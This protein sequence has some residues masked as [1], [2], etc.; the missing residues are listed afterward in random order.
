MNKKYKILEHTADI[1]VQAFGKNVP[2]LF[3]N[4]LKGM[5]HITKPDFKDQKVKV[6]FEIKADDF[7][8]LLIEFLSEALYFS[9]VRDEVYE[10]VEFK[11]FNT[12][13]YIIKGAFKG[14][15]IKGLG[16]EIK[17]VTWH[18]ALVEKKKDFW[19]SKILF[20]I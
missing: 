5:A 4:N 20:D 14:K 18:D 19:T 8:S 10:E 16:L 3:L 13:K 15:K 9:D 2:E 1:G 12:D 7:E 11:E 6:D 17:A